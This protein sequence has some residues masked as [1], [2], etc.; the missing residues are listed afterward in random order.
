MNIVRQTLFIAKKSRTLHLE[1]VLSN[2]Q[3]AI[4]KNN[5]C[6]YFE[7]YKSDDC[8]EEFLVYEEWNNSDS[9]DIFY[10]GKNYSPFEKD[11][12][13]ELYKKEILPTF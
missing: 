4:L 9:M 10:N 1:V 5:E 2:L 13:I 12:K 3:T 7:I 6:I 8:E 11:L